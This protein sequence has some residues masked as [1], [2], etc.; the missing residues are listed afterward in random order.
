LLSR[1]GG[2]HRNALV[3]ACIAI[4]VGTA[5]WIA[6]AVLTGKREPWDDSAYWTVAYPAALLASALLGYFYPTLTWRWPLLIFEAQLVA[7]CV[8]NGEPGNLWP[9]GMVLFA[10]VA[11]PGMLTA[12]VA[13]RLKRWAGDDEE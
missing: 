3:P 10:I 11:L 13:S 4:A 9:I 8:R 12:K 7:Q 5:L 1:I 6:A 2:W